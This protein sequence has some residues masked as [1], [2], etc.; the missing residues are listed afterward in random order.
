M[1]DETDE[2]V[3]AAEEAEGKASD[4][5]HYAKKLQEAIDDLKS[6]LEEP[7]HCDKCKTLIDLRK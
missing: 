7:K 2:L 1:S 5:V 4:V 3:E 6:Q